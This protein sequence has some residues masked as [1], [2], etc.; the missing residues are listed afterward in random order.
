MQLNSLVRKQSVPKGLVAY[1]GEGWGE[2][3]P[4]LLE[5]GRGDIPVFPVHVL[6][7][8]WG[9]WASDTAESTGAPV[10]YVV[11]GLLA[12][13]AAVS[14]AGIEAEVNP[15]WREP[16]VLWSALVGLPSSGKSPALG[17]TRRLIEP[18]EQEMRARD[19]DRQR[20][21]DTKVEQARLL[22]DKWKGEC[23]AALERG[24]P[25]PLKPVEATFDDDFIPSQIVVADATI[26]ALVDVVSGNPRGVVLWRDE[27]AAWL[28]NLGRYSNGS[29]RPQYL[30][31]WAAASVTINR[32][33][34]RG[35]L[36]IGRFPVSII[37]S[38]QPDRI[39]EALYG[40]DDGMAARFLYAWPVSP[41]YRSILTC[42]TVDSG[43]AQVRLKRIAGISGTAEHP[44]ILYISG[45]A[46]ALLDAFLSDLHA[47]A[48]HNDG[49]EAGFLGKGRGTVVRLATALA[50][51]RWSEAEETQAPHVIDLDS[52]RDAAGLW[53]DYFRPHARA[54]FNQAGATGRDRYLRKAIRWLRTSRTE[55][56]S[57]E[58]IRCAALGRAVDAEGADQVIARLVS[59]NVL[60]RVKASTSRGRPPLRWSVNP[61]LF[62]TGGRD[63]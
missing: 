21:H 53:A 57:R 48:Q 46:Q 10:D 24:A 32:K 47:E 19:G 30:E 31:A 18:I 14:G 20:E 1:D 52:M 33:S 60:R 43:S 34:R 45:E 39:A 37:G 63:A 7:T 8:A 17:A 23:E 44:R 36:H 26:E 5:G 9:Q 15:G 2:I 27:L 62:Q 58:D 51:L 40:A 16:L 25:A 13:V 50:L 55:E 12:S 4:S 49:L 61:A 42:P 29:D 11:Q 35:P 6:P 38:I 56:I 59:A 54:V 41:K 28:G 22:E 3:D